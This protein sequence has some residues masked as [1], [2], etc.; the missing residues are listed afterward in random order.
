MGLEQVRFN[1]IRITEIPNYR[2]HT[3]SQITELAASIVKRGLL[4][5]LLVKEC[6]EDGKT[7]YDVV[8]GEGRY[9]A[10]AKIRETEPRAMDYVP[11]L[12]YRG[13]SEDAAFSRFVAN[14]DRDG[15]SPI[16]QADFII[17]MR[18][19]KLPVTEIASKAHI[20]ESYAYSL[21]TVME[22]CHPEVLKAL[23]QDRITFNSALKLSKMPEKKQ[24]DE[25]KNYFE[26]RE[27]GGVKAGSR[28]ISGNKRPSVRELK[29][30]HELSAKMTEANLYSIEV[31][32]HL[33]HRWLAIKDILDW[34]LGLSSRP[35]VQEEE[36]EFLD[37]IEAAS[38]KKEE[39]GKSKR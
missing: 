37:K 27:K 2:K 8:D 6:K 10:I 31:P 14:N 32:E 35:E 29:T 23:R 16:E 36:Q 38:T 25:L 18:N 7:F 15:H 1:S 21:I 33:R 28:S 13:N 17:T 26:A 5:P 3:E 24:P 22:K 34:T 19:K 11:A 39:G 30:Y 4:Q 20:T 12:L 9:L